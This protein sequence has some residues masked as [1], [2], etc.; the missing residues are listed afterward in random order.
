MRLISFCLSDYGMG[1]GHPRAITFVA[2]VMLL[3]AAARND[4]AEVRRLLE[5]GI[6]PDSTNEDGLTALHQVGK[7]HV[8]ERC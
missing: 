5:S 4:V 8:F 7:P 6:S 2:N 3:E 1:S